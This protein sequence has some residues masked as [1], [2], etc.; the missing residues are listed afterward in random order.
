[1]KEERSPQ[2]FANWNLKGAFRPLSNRLN[3]IHRWQIKQE[4][5]CTP[6]SSKPGI[7]EHTDG[8]GRLVTQDPQT[9][10]EI[11]GQT[12]CLIVAYPSKQKGYVDPFFESH[13]VKPKKKNIPELIF[14]NPFAR[15]SRVKLLF[16]AILK[17][18]I[19]QISEKGGLLMAIRHQDCGF[20]ALLTVW[21]IK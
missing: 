14:V 4:K 10:P 2:L 18:N 20:W 15:I 21:S 8:S 12:V 11:V 16:P 1:M 17:A 19:R 6:R 13:S 9:T 3:M 5:G 7:C